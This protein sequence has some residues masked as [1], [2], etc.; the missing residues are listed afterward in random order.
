MN[1]FVKAAYYFSTTLQSLNLVNLANN[2][3]IGIQLADFLL[4]GL[5]LD[6]RVRE[7]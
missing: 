4:I 5:L 3:Q 7:G 2:E 1:I 6:S